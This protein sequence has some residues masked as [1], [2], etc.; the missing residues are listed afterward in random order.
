MPLVGEHGDDGVRSTTEDLIPNQLNSLWSMYTK[1]IRSGDC[2]EE[3][4]YER[5]PSPSRLLNPRPRRKRR[6]TMRRP[7]HIARL[8]NNFRRL[9][10]ANISPSR[11]PCFLTLTFREVVDIDQGY[12]SLTKFGLKLRKQFGPSLAW[13]SV[14]EYQKRGAIHFH[15]LVFGLADEFVDTERKTRL[16]AGLWGN[17]FV[18]LVPTDGA[19]QIASYMAK[20]M[21]KAMGD[22]RL[23]G[24][25]A[26]SATRNVLRPV[27]LSSD[28]SI[29]SAWDYFRDEIGA[30]DK[31]VVLERDY[32][33]MFLGR[34]KYRQYV[35]G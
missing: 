28:C 2:V 14:P 15:I 3:Y 8:R 12:K 19:P 26:Y 13:I 33:T 31:S 32:D 7:D 18:D 24:K 20:Y 29:R 9:V 17:G 27:S 11:P 10:R 25:K 5:Q 1:L 16:I 23:L 4:V 22:Y 34:C 35:I 21:G 6:A 30:V